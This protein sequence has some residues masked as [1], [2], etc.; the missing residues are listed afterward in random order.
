[1]QP[2]ADRAGGYGNDH[3]A[4]AACRLQN[5]PHHLQGPGRQEMKRALLIISLSM[6]FAEAR[7]EDFGRL[8]FTP[9]QRAALDARRRARVP[10]KPAAVVI[11]SPTTRVDG[12][13]K[14]NGGPSTVF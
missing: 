6:L 3:H 7:A 2:D 13:V 12:Y 14:R 4:A 9:D 1:M 5:R 11:A 8:F 10:D